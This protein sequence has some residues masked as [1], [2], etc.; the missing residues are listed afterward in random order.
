MTPA[1]YDRLTELASNAENFALA[2]DAFELAD[3]K[4][5]VRFQPVLKKRRTLNQNTGGVVTLGT[6][7]PSVALYAGPTSRDKIKRR[8]AAANATT[9]DGGRRS[10]TNTEPKGSGREGPSLGNVNRGDRI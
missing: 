6:A 2:K 9:E 5:L 10:P 8:N 4:L 3:A 1:Q 7:P